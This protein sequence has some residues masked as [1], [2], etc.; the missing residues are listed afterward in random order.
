MKP[1]DGLGLSTGHQKLK[2]FISEYFVDQRAWW[3]GK[4]SVLI[5]S[6]L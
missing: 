1:A 2:K 5:E 6:W 4:Y 3:A